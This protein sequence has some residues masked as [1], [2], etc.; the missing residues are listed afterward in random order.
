MFLEE[1][2]ILGLDSLA[3]SLAILLWFKRN[4]KVKIA[5]VGWAGKIRNKAQD[6]KAFYGTL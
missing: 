6:L 1:V 3:T 4:V 5:L 2:V